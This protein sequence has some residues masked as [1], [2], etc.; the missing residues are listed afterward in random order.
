MPYTCYSPTIYACVY[1]W[2]VF[3]RVKEDEAF[4]RAM[5]SVQNYSLSRYLSISMHCSLFGS[6][7]VIVAYSWIF[8]AQAALVT[9]RHWQ[10]ICFV[11]H[12]LK[13]REQHGACMWNYFFYV[14]VFY[15]HILFCLFSNIFYV[16]FYSVLL[17]LFYDV[18]WFASVFLFQDFCCIHLSF[19]W[20]C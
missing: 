11:S 17:F 1:F 20:F 9:W 13:S 14:I 16:A 19:I 15:R 2:L 6:L 18:L 3:R 10:L 12:P 7:F 4:V 8:I 5:S